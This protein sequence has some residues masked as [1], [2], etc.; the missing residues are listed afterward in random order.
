MTVA[1]V[2]RR[3]RTRWIGLCDGLKGGTMV[4][5]ISVQ[6]MLCGFADIRN[7]RDNLHEN[8]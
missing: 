8:H 6:R 1:H 3:G 2:G 7:Q 5:L 4:I